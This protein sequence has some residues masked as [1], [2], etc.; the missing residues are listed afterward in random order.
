MSI[1]DDVV[2]NVKTAAESAQK[3]AGKIVDVSKL[4][5]HLSEISGEITSKYTV[6]GKTMYKNTKLEQ[7]SQVEID[8]I[9]KEIDELVGQFHMLVN[10]INL[11]EDKNQCDVCGKFYQTDATFCPY[12]GSQVEIK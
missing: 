7:E 12:C 5:I 3:T 10:E 6:L 4:R 2:I 1:L 8:E 9:I 11:M